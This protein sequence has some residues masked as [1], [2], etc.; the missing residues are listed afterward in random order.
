M[1]FVTLGIFLVLNL[2]GQSEVSAVIGLEGAM[3]QMLSHG[4][5]S[6]ALFFCIG[7]IYEKSHSRKIEDN[8]GVAQYMPFFSLEYLKN[9]DQLLYVFNFSD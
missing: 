5:I 3:I 9:K 8:Y 1:G 2:L 6:A 4:L 7:I